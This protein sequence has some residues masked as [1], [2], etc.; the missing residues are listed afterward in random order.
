MILFIVSR[1]KLSSIIILPG[2]GGFSLTR[3]P[4]EI[5]QRNGFIGNSFRLNKFPNLL[6]IS[7]PVRYEYEGDVTIDNHL[8][9]IFINL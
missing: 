1:I 5:C 7:E 3:N 4:R 6:F 9:L 8:S 2:V